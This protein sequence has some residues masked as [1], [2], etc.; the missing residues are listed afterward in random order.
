M[1]FLINF[2]LLGLSLS[3]LIWGADKFVDNSSIIAKNLGISELTIGLTVVALGTS[4]PEIFVGISSIIYE[5]EALAMGAVVG[6]NISNIA[7][8]FG[9]SCIGIALKPHKTP[10]IQFLPFLLSALVLGYSLIDLQITPIE[11]ILMLIVFAYFLYVTFKNR[12]TNNLISEVSLSKENSFR[13]VAFLL[14]GLISLIVGSNYAVIYAEKIALLLNIS[15]LV[16]GLTIIAIGTSLPELAATISALIKKKTDMVVGNVIGSN[17]LNITLVVP[18]VGLFSSVKLEQILLE[19]DYLIM[20]S[21]SVL[22]VIM[23]TNY[24]SK[25]I[26]I[27]M[28]RAIGMLFLFGY[29]TYILKLSGLI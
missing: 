14:L 28:I 27:L 3:V 21:L 5:T 16:I 22:F 23:A 4:A 11:S 17:V 25:K 13:V 9:V 6:S 18:I 8:I 24:S 19:R 1:D 7:L 20:I 10:F 12:S 29:I 2:L 26:S 15:E